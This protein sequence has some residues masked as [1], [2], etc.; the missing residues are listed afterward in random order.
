MTIPQSQTRANDLERQI[1]HNLPSPHSVPR[2]MARGDLIDVRREPWC[3]ESSPAALTRAITRT[4]DFFVRTNFVIPRLDAESHVVQIGGAV[5]RASEITVTELRKLG[6]ETIDVT[7]ECAG[8]GRTAMSPLP[9]GEMWR[10]GAVGTARWTG[11]PLA[12]VLE[13]AS[14]ADDAVEVLVEGADCGQPRDTDATVAF[15]RAL[16]M[17]VALDPDTILALEMNGTPIPPAHGAPV[18]LIVPGWYGMASVKWVSRIAVLATPFAGYFQSSRYVYDAGD[19]TKA[20]PVRRMRVKC[21]IA[22]PAEG[23]AV[24]AGRVMVSGWAWSGEGEITRVE[25]SAGGGENWKDAQLFPPTSEHGWRG[26]QIEWDAA[27]RGRCALRCRA[28][29]SAGNVQPERAEWNRLGYGNNAIHAAMVD[30]K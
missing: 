19:G 18:R 30:V 10:H 4:E 11:V 12:R 21:M 27:D 17:H 28:T 5:R 25:F 9:A 14:F 20:T 29:D 3:A 7:L 1:T 24:P 26:W 8:N 22:A 23:M 6:T 13:L 15:A 2:E 16:P